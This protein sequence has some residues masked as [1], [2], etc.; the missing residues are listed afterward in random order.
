[1][2][3]E[4]LDGCIATVAEHKKNMIEAIRSY[5][6]DSNEQILGYTHTLEEVARFLNELNEEWQDNT[7]AYVYYGEGM[8][9]FEIRKATG[10]ERYSRWTEQHNFSAR[11][12]FNVL[13]AL[14]GKH[15]ESSF[16]LSNSL[17]E[18]DYNFV[19]DLLEKE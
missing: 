10:Q 9:H 12:Y 11:E 14:T 8:N 7:E 3:I 5:M 2:D 15:T 17:T 4:Y 6:A 1:M 13:R 16:E 18:D 19:M